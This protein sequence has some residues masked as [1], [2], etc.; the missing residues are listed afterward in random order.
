MKFALIEMLTH[1]KTPLQKIDSNTQIKKL[2]YGESAVLLMI[3]NH[4]GMENANLKVSVL[5][6]F[7]KYFED[8]SISFH[9]CSQSDS[10]VSVLC[11]KGVL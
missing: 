11:F 6:V 8:A 9:E 5:W 2:N 7:H 4:C 10:T 3:N 1:L